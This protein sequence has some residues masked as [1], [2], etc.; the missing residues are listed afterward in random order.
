MDIHENW[1]KALQGTEII[2]SRVKNLKTFSDTKVPYVILSKS[3]MNLGDTVVRKGKVLV[4]RPSIILP[5]HIPQLY[6]FDLDDQGAIN[7]NFI[8]NFLMIRGISMPSLKYNNELY[9][10][11]IHEGNLGGAISFYNND[12]QRKEDVHTGLVVAPDECW[13]LSLLIFICA[14]VA[15]NAETDIKKLLERYKEEGEADNN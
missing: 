6:G 13:S 7:E 10:V 11:D 1:E 3:L 15:R 14:Q 9:S 2:R 4:S 8:T 12:L 5:P